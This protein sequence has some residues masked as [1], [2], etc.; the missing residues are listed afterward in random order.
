MLTVGADSY[1]TAEEADGILKGEPDE[2]RWKALSQEQKESYLKSAARNIEA[3]PL[4]G[5]KHSVFQAMAFPRDMNRVIP[6]IVKQAQAFEALALT[7]RQA[8]SRRTLQEQGV[9]SISLGKASESYT[10]RTS[11]ELLSSDAARLLRPYL[12]GSGAIL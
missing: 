9:A 5:R 7:D 11:T 6:D 12:L 1:I 2:G 4:R 3:L 8:V 10:G